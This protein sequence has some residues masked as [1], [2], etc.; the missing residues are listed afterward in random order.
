VASVSSSVCACSRS[1]KW[2]EV[3]VRWRQALFHDLVCYL[4]DGI[5]E[6]AL[7]ADHGAFVALGER[8]EC[9]QDIVNAAGK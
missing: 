4:H 3:L 5:D 9:I 2:R 7:Q 8:V 1:E 6:T